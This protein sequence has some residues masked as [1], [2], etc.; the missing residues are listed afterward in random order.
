MT[1]DTGL[2]HQVVDRR[3]PRDVDHPARA[4]LAAIDVSTLV[5]LRDRV[6]F[7]TRIYTGAR[8]GAVVRLRRG[9]L[10]DRALRILDKGGKDRTIPVHEDLEARLA[11]TARLSATAAPLRRSSRASSA[12]PARAPARDL[13]RGAGAAQARAA[14]CRPARAAGGRTP[15]GS[16]S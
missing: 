16:L 11:P 1:V 8:V 12:R 2:K 5:G 14:C 6:L 4:L 10:Q 13:G 3:K 9:D 15:S 7:G